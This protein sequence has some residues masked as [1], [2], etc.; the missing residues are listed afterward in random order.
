[1]T[2]LEGFGQRV[3]TARKRLGMTQQQLGKLSRMDRTYIGGIE[4]GE[5]NITLLNVLRLARALRVKPAALLDDLGDP[6]V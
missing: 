2:A 3:R 4:R 6:D 1:L 5:R